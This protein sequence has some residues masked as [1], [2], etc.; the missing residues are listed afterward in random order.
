M[1]I[2]T[3]WI[4]VSYCLVLCEYL[5]F[6]IESNSYLLFYSIRNW[7]NYSKF[8]N[9]NLWSAGLLRRALFVLWQP[10]AAVVEPSAAMRPRVCVRTP[11]TPLTT[12][13]GELLQAAVS[14]WRLMAL[15]NGARQTQHT[16]SWALDFLSVLLICYGFNFNTETCCI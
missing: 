13:R 8:S 14:P 12:A 7:R 6:R 11:P 5:K 16:V 15:Y 9:T 1:A 3:M 2:K 10:Q 4:Y